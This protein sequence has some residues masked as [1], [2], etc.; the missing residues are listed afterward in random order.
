[1]TQKEMIEIIREQ[2]PDRMESELR[3]ILNG[4]NDQFVDETQILRQWKAFASTTDTIEYLFADIAVFG[5]AIPLYISELEV[6]QVPVPRLPSHSDKAWTTR[7]DALLV[8][9]FATRQG[10]VVLTSLPEGSEISL[11]AAFNDPGFSADLDAEPG[12]PKAFHEA[13]LARAFEKLSART[14]NLELARYWKNEY[15]EYRLRAKQWMGAR[16]TKGNYATPIGTFRST[17]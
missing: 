4:A 2:F 16:G 6:D 10:N 5:G 7:Q 9:N 3:T 1:M 15:E 12:Y 11:Y 17:Q 13:V 14:G 8:G